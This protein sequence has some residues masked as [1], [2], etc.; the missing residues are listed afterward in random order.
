MRALKGDSRYG[1]PPPNARWNTCVTDLA[2]IEPSFCLISCTAV[3][4]CQSNTEGVW[5][6]RQG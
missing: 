4:A 5:V 3:T 2:F 6:Q 1:I